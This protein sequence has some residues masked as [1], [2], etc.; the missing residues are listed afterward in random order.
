MKVIIWIVC[1]MIPAIIRTSE[2]KSGN[3][4]GG[5]P[6]LIM[7]SIF[8]GLAKFLCDKWTDYKCYR[9]DKAL[10]EAREEYVAANISP[11]I[12]EKCE[13]Y[14]AN[15]VALK[16]Y[17]ETIVSEEKITQKQSDVLYRHFTDPEIN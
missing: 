7:Y 6:V 12:V 3:Y 15:K 10:Q 14:K 1:L 9:A 13:A 11:D 4:M 16:T 2:A 8:F 17:L 5:I